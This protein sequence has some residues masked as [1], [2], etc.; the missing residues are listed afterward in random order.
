MNHC[1][2][3]L[4]LICNSYM[5]KDKMQF[6]NAVLRNFVKPFLVLSLAVDYWRVFLPLGPFSA[7]EAQ[8]G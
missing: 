6:F 8:S 5:I 7:V 4:G 3:I 2:L 1:A